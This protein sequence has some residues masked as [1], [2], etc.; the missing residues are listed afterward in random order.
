MSIKDRWSILNIPQL[1]TQ[2]VR[3]EKNANNTQPHDGR[4][5]ELRVKT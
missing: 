2:R 4:F 5:N 1:I 3:I